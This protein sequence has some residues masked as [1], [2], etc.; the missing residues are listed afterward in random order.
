MIEKLSARGL[1]TTVIIIL[2]VGKLI[3]NLINAV[4]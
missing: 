2:V 3:V 1:A 4:F